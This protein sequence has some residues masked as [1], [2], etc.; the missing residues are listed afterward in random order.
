MKGGQY[1]GVADV[2]ATVIGGG[3]I[4]FVLG[5]FVY[6]AWDELINEIIGKR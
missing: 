6:C 3:F 4:L 5:L 2:I 1:M